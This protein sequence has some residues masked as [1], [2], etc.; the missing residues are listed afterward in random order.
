MKNTDE[1][2][3]SVNKQIDNERKNIEK[4]KE[5]L[6]QL[7]AQKKNLEIQKKEEEFAELKEILAN[8]G[9]N[10]KSDFE[11]FIRE[12]QNINFINSAERQ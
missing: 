5:K 3:L 1:K 12:N 9:I 4:S 10:S 11:K 8:Y 2:L 6:K 7:N